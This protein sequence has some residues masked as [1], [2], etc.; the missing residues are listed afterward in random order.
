MDKELEEL[1][2]LL[3]LL[4]GTGVQQDATANPPTQG[5]SGT[6]DIDFG[7][8]LG[9]VAENVVLGQDP[10]GASS[11]FQDPERE[12]LGLQLMAGILGPGLPAGAAAK[13]LGKADEMLIGLRKIVERGDMI[14]EPD[15]YIKALDEIVDE[16][17]HIGEAIHG[18]NTEVVGRFVRPEKYPEEVVG[19]FTR[20][21]DGR[22][23]YMSS[24]DDLGF[25]LE[26]LGAEFMEYTPYAIQ[27][28]MNRGQ[29][30]GRL[31]TNR[32]LA[33]LGARAVVHGDEAAKLAFTELRPTD[34]G[35]DDLLA[36]KARGE[37]Y[38]DIF[39]GPD[40]L[41]NYQLLEYMGPYKEGL[42]KFYDPF[43]AEAALGRNLSDV[44]LYDFLLG[45]GR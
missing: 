2:R 16:R 21:E 1:E 9:K 7:E 44:T 38:L 31:L 10:T 35:I 24:M 39:E 27:D 25:E 17:Q 45:L 13:I 41:S 11:L 26:H 40:G 22:R 42:A 34:L 36:K 30:M 18:A 20:R 4:G 14:I 19:Q 37:K 6:I 29:I 23:R 8:L 33:E 12:M 5:G 28:Q 15:E 32:S 43:A 3:A